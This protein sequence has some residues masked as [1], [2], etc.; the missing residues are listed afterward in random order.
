MGNLLQCNFTGSKPDQGFPAFV[1]PVTRGVMWLD[2]DK[3]HF[4][5]GNPRRGRNPKFEEIQASILQ[6]GDLEQPLPISFNP[7]L[8]Q[9]VIYKGGNTRLEIVQG[10][11]ASGD[12]RFFEVRCEYHPWEGWIESAVWHFIENE[13]RGELTLIDK[14]LHIKRIKDGLEKIQGEEY[15]LRVFLDELKRQ[16]IGISVQTLHSY[17]SAAKYYEYCPLAFEGGVGTPFVKTLNKLN[18]AIGYIHNPQESDKPL[19]SPEILGGVLR[20]IDKSGLTLSEVEELLI[21]RLAEALELSEWQAG[22]LLA[23]AKA[24]E[25]LGRF[26][27]EGLQEVSSSKPDSS[28]SPSEPDPALI[29]HLD[30]GTARQILLDM[31]SQEGFRVLEEAESVLSRVETVEGLDAIIGAAV[32]KKAALQGG[33]A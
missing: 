15:K 12:T 24:G 5:D 13:M 10:A 17:L 31:G 21:H 18:S 9:F 3:I 30:W 26:F 25:D 7:D 4:F 32:A 8:G 23:A 33:D 1:E 11:K 29:S 14:A 28:S 16:G 19:V 27:E 6:M 22:Q 2:P 20:D